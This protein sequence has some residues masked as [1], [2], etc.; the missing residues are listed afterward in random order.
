[1]YKISN[2]LEFGNIS[3]AEE[4]YCEW[5]CQEGEVLTML[6]SDGEYWY[7]MECAKAIIGFDITDEEMKKLKKTEIKAKLKYFRL[8]VKALRDELKELN[9]QIKQ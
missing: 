1:M 8:R 6:W 3:F 7:C 4:S 9:V 5:C 2:E